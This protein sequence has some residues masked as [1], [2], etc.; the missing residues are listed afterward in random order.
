MIYNEFYKESISKT[1]CDVFGKEY[2]Y[3]IISKEDVNKYKNIN[4]QSSE[5]EVVKQVKSFIEN[6]YSDKFT[7]DTYLRSEFNKECVDICKDIAEQKS[8]LNI[9]FISGASGIGKTHLLQAVGNRFEERG[10][11]SIYINP[12]IFN[13]KILLALQENNSTYITKIL[14]HLSSVDIVL[15][16]DFQ[17]FG[18]ER[19]KQTKN[20]IYQII[21]ARIHKNKPTIIS[22][23]M[24]IKDI[25]PMFDERLLTRIQS[26]FLSKIK[27]P[28]ESEYKCLLD[29]LFEKN[30]INVDIVDE[31]S[32]SFLI[33][34]YSS[35]I[36]SLLGVVA[37]VKYYKNDLMNANYAFNVVKNI[38]GDSTSLSIVT[39]PEIIV[40][41]VSSYYKVT[42]KEIM[43]KTRR[44]EIVI[45]RHICIILMDNLLSM[46]STEIGKVLNKDHTT[47]LNALKK[48]KNE[49]TESSIKLAIEQIKKDIRTSK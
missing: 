34:E 8:D 33:K 5:K 7:F 18:E 28:K 31:E 22:T 1:I 41:K 36:R 45:A 44:K 46:S 27:K 9:L 39:T 10:K 6:E 24:D 17:I 21:D 40:K 20:F 19:K 48:S 43:G 38:F 49:G 32:K 26:G 2:K 12:L 37:K 25:E 47:V 14:N 11:K 29:F 15:F 23:E 30:N 13:K 3:K 35:S 4:K 16:D 42:A